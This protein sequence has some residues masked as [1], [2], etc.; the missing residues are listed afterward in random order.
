M[1]KLLYKN[2]TYEAYQDSRSIGSVRL[3]KNPCHAGNCYMELKLKEPDPDF[4]A[5]LFLE[6]GKLAGRPLQVMVSSEDSPVI[7]FLSAGGFTCKRK[8]YEVEAG[9][10]DFIGSN[11]KAYLLYTS[12]GEKVYDLCCSILY[13]HYLETHKDI[14]PWTAGVAEF[15]KNLPSEAIY[16]ADGDQIINLA[17]VEENEIAYICGSKESRFADFAASLVNELF[18]KYDTVCFESDDCDRAAMGLRALF[19]NQDETSFDTYV[20]T[21]GGGDES[22]GQLQKDY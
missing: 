13:E 21:L 11:Y 22:Y 16:E 18:L 6:L 2:G 10:S 9:R 5:E 12:S 8:C 20:Y 7:E 3:Y 19:A 4:A 14:S 1:I 17:F 15:C